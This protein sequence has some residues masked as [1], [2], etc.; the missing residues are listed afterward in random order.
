MNKKA[1]SVKFVVI[2]SIAFILFGMAFV[3]FVKNPVL[4]SKA[5]YAEKECYFIDNERLTTANANDCCAEI[6][7]STGCKPY[8]NDLFIC[9]GAINVAVN[10]ETIEFC[11]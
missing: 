7:K 10:K 9:K 3:S 5:T 4:E 11:G 8:E 1:E 6:K 2:T